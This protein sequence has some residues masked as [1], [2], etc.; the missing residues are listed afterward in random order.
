[1]AKGG[2][3]MEVAEKI[4]CKKKWGIIEWWLFI[5]FIALIELVVLHMAYTHGADKEILSHVSFAG[6]IA[7]MILAVVAIIYGFIQATS[8]QT[9]SE[10]IAAQVDSL[11]NVVRNV[12]ASQGV[13]EGVL[14]KLESVANRVD[15]LGKSVSQ[16]SAATSDAI[17]SLHGDLKAML[18]VEKK[19]PAPSAPQ[20]NLSTNINYILENLGGSAT[21]TAYVVLRLEGKNVDSYKIGEK[22]LLYIFGR[23]TREEYFGPDAKDKEMRF[24]I[25][26]MCGAVMAASL[27]FMRALGWVK[28][29]KG[30]PVVLSEDFKQIASVYFE[31]AL[32]QSSDEAGSWIQSLK[33]IKAAIDL[34]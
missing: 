8:Q 21:V 22:Y 14:L 12:D 32:T 4:K 28:S 29:E 9:S 20:S 15:D 19:D 34:G 24:F 2:G 3:G 27:E 11:R 30:S 7:S 26:G 31:K 18:N 10:K 6:T 5:G 13:V 25:E 17:S 23:E 1:L 16:S 33:E